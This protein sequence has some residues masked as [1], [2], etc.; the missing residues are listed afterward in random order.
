M[1]DV[2][3]YNETNLESNYTGTGLQPGETYKPY[4][5]SHKKL[6]LILAII[7]GIIGLVYGCYRASMAYVMIGEDQYEVK[8]RK[9]VKDNNNYAEVLSED[10]IKVVYLGEET[11]ISVRSGNF[12]FYNYYL[13]NGK[14]LTDSGLGDSYIY[15]IGESIVNDKDIDFSG[16]PDFFWYHRDT[17]AKIC[18]VAYEGAYKGQDYLYE[19][20][21]SGGFIFLG[22]FLY[23]AALFTMAYPKSVFWGRRWMMKDQDPELSEEGL[24]WVKITNGILAVFGWLLM[25]GLFDTMIRATE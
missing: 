25:A 23:A 8:G 16:N 21:A 6:G 14:E 4:V 17:I 9:V 22:A 7:I 18:Q 20:V 2:E 19:R 15:M 24:F 5:K 12:G 10:T 11:K 13:P 3:K 1:D